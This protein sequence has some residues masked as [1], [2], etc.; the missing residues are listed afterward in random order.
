MDKIRVFLQGS[1]FGVSN[2]VVVIVAVGILALL[3]RFGTTG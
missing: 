2:Y 3:A 1:T